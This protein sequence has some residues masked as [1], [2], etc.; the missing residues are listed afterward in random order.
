MIAERPDVVLASFARCALLVT[1]G[2]E[3]EFVSGC[4]LKFPQSFEANVLICRS[5]ELDN[6]VL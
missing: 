4:V 2:R 3:N 6:V 1:G 5:L